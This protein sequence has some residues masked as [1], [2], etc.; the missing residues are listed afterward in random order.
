MVKGTTIH[1]MFAHTGNVGHLLTDVVWP[2]IAVAA[3]RSSFTPPLA[4]ERATFLVQGM[5]RAVEGRPADELDGVGCATFPFHPWTRN[6][7]G[8]YAAKTLI[9]AANV[10]D[11]RLLFDHLLPPVRTIFSYH[12]CSLCAW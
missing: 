9:T 4:L 2:H 10:S 1:L 8:D 3:W 11:A 12:Y 5:S 7:F 6:T